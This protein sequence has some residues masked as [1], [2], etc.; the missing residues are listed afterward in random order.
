MSGMRRFSLRVHPAGW[1]M[2]LA[3]LL[4]APAHTVLSAAAA[5]LLHE[6]AHLAA[7]YLCGVACC[8]LELTPFG[9]M[10]DAAGYDCLPVGKQAAIAISGVAASAAAAWGCY[11]FAPDTPFWYGLFCANLSL[12]LMNCLPLWPLDGARVMLALARKLGFADAA[13][14]VMLWLAYLVSLLVAAIGLY[15]VWLGTVNLTLLCI[16][17]YLCYAARRCCLYDRLRSFVACDEHGLADGDM[18]PVRLY[19]CMGQPSSMM[20]CRLLKEQGRGYCVLM[21]LNEHGEDDVAFLDER[22]MVARL[23]GECKH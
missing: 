7:M 3:A 15:G 12:G 22:Q 14:K 13:R 19:A 11:T 8:E 4:F 17:P 1:V 21:M 2:L 6:G 10:A 16:G 5:L 20:L 9:G 18:R 23:F